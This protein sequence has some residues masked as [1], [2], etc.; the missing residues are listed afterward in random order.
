MKISTKNLIYSLLVMLALMSAC[1]PSSNSIYYYNPEE[2]VV[3]PEI[4]ISV[5]LSNDL[6]NLTDDVHIV[7][8]VKDMETTTTGGSLKT[9]HIQ[10][11]QIDPAH[12]DAVIKTLLVK[13]PD[14]NSKEGYTINEKFVVNFAASTVYCRLTVVA[15][16]Q[17]DRFDTKEVRFSI[18]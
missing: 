2:D 6:Y 12:D 18:Q 1:K 11:D 16:D 10:V 17:T 15:Y 14:V 5:P 13:N 7:G 8:T 3:A 9:L 4:K